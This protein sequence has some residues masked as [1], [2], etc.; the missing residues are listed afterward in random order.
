MSQGTSGSAGDEFGYA[1]GLTGS[2]AVYWRTRPD[3]G[4][5]CRVPLL[6]SRWYVVIT[7]HVGGV[8]RG[9][10]LQVRHLAGRIELQLRSSARRR[11]ETVVAPSMRSGPAEATGSKLPS[12]RPRPTSS[13]RC[14]ASPSRFLGRLPLSV[15]TGARAMWVPGTCSP[16]GQAFRRGANRPS[17]WRR[18]AKEGAISSDGRWRLTERRW[19]L[20]RLGAKGSR[21]PRVYTSNG[22]TWSLAAEITDPGGRDGDMFGFAVAISG[23]TVVIGAPAAIAEHTAA[24]VYHQSGSGWVL[25][26][27]LVPASGHPAHFG[28]A[29]AVSAST[30]VVSASE[31][32]YVFSSEGGMWSQ[33]QT[34]TPADGASGDRYGFAVGLSRSA[35]VVGAPGHDA[36]AGIAYFY[37][38]D[39]TDWTL[40]S[41][42][43]GS[44][45][46][47]GN[48]FGSAVAV[49]ETTAIVG[50]PGSNNA[51]NINGH[52]G[53]AYV[54]T[55]ANGTWSQ[56]AEV[57]GSDLHVGQ[58]YGD[59]VAISGRGHIVAAAAPG[60]RVYVFANTDGRWSQVQLLTQ[61]PQPVAAFDPIMAALSRSPP[62]W[63]WPGPS[64]ATHE[65]A[66]SSSRRGEDRGSASG[67]VAIRLPSRWRRP[68]QRYRQMLSC[69]PDAVGALRKV[70]GP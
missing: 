19:W 22:S 32:V 10:W 18:T 36:G 15:P 16:R 46:A 56:Q 17:C 21:A 3:S 51:Q 70:C 69:T 63:W 30:A 5:G 52:T 43:A 41:E 57:L 12:S 25:Q 13:A 68:R 6:L 29:V 66:P 31:G 61:P 35:L 34:L 59:S 1:V 40:Q 38:L 28:H 49:S 53:T 65:R 37:G 62:P 23:R 2:T 67:D 60:G 58:V 50:A 7:G 8:G 47:G 20:A 24:Y 14:S 33:V 54:F 48:V 45:P 11:T 64:A 26:S 27:T 55:A 44:D 9:D 42:L 4:D 39:H